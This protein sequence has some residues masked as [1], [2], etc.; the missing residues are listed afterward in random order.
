MRQTSACKSFS[1]KHKYFFDISN[2]FVLPDVSEEKNKVSFV[3]FFFFASLHLYQNIPCPPVHQ[4]RCI[5]SLRC[6]ENLRIHAVF[7][8]PL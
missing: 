4:V 7:Y 6:T 3:P 1:P 2:S 5:Q 8:T